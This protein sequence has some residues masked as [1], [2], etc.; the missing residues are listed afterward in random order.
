MTGNVILRFASRKRGM[1]MTLDAARAE[2]E[3]G[4]FV[5][6]AVIRRSVSRDGLSETTVTR[7]VSGRLGE[8]ATVRERNDR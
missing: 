4:G 7:W 6:G 5:P 1:R 2:L 8:T 3:A